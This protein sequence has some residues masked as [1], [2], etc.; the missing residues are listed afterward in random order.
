M[1]GKYLPKYFL[2]KTSFL[3]GGWGRAASLKSGEEE[4][5][6]GSGGA[7]CMCI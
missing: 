6:C 1:E 4:N 2:P 3:G 7:G 5:W